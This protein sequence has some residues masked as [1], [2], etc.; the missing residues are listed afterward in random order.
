MLRF[1][2]FCQLF[3]NQMVL[4]LVFL[5]GFTRV[6]SG[7]LGFT[8][9]YSGLLEFTRVNLGLIRHSQSTRYVTLF[10]KWIRSELHTMCDPWCSGVT[11]PFEYS[12]TSFVSLSN[13]FCCH[14]LFSF[15]HCIEG[16]SGTQSFSLTNELRREATPNKRLLIGSARSKDLTCAPRRGLSRSA[17]P[18]R[19]TLVCEQNLWVLHLKKSAALCF[20]ASVIGVLIP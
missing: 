12:L 20:L 8:R 11:N 15:N 5:L 1:L 13:Y 16:S 18:L 19:L 2:I 3:W 4:V 9:V 7:L 14:G 6:Y 17:S 10:H